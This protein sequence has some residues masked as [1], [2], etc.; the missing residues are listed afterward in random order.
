[1]PGMSCEVKLQAYR[2]TDALAV[3]PSAVGD[4][5]DA[6]AKHFVMLLGKNGKPQKQAVTVG[7]RTAKLV[8][9]CR[10]SAKATR[11]SRSAPQDKDKNK[12]KESDG[13]S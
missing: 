10:A 8:E 6:P 7:R 3:P 13:D 1:M 12:D 9:S 4:D 11:S 2:K 5:D